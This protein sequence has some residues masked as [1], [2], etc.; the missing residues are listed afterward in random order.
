MKEVIMK[1]K[2]LVLSGALV[3]T[4]LISGIILSSVRVLADEI[5]TARSSAKASVTVSAACTLAGTVDTAHNAT[6]NAGTY[7]DEI[8]KTTLK[9]SCNDP[10]GFAIYAIGFTDDTYGK[11][12]LTNTTLGDI[13]TGTAQSGSTSNWAMKLEITGQEAANQIELQ[14]NFNNYRVI[15]DEY[16]LAA[17]KTAGTT[18]EEGV[19]L[20]STYAAYISGTQTVGTYTGKVKYTLVHPNYGPKPVAP[21][22]PTDCQK[23]GI[24]YA[25]N[26]SDIIGSMRSLGAIS[27]SETAGRVS[28][29]ANSTADL[30]APNFKREGYGFAGWSTEFNITDINNTTATIYG[31][32]E[33]IS[34]NPNDGGVDISQN[35]LILYPVWVAAET[36][37][38]MQT[39]NSTSYPAYNTAP[40]GTIIALKDERDNDV[41]AVAKLADG[42]WWMIENLRLDNEA[43]INAT[44]TQ[45]NNG[46]FGGVFN[47]LDSSEDTNFSNT[48]N[49]TP[50][51]LYSGDNVTGSYN[52]NRIPRYNNNNTNIGGTNASGANLNP[53]RNGGGTTSQWYSYGNYYSWAAAIADTTAHNTNNESVTKTS[54][55]PVNWR[56]PEGGMAYAA[57]NTSGVNV[58]GDT[59]TYRDFYNLGYKIVGSTAYENTPNNGYSYYNGANYSNLFRAYP[60]NFVYSGS[61]DG[62]S[63]S[64]RGSYG[65]YWSSSANNSN[66]AYYLRFASSR[67]CPGTSSSYKNYGFSVRC[68]AGS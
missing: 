4:T 5:V 2:E 37:V 26:A 9:A 3:F 28:A 40:N 31:P 13:V 42:N 46:A 48:T 50:N 36:S 20:A 66:T 54:I 15:P 35:G 58:T 64:T 41:Y 25:A 60:N 16:T 57:G 8:G 34:T 18:T 32:N 38:T 44:N 29:S 45:S 6:V 30:I 12:V 59:S 53:S 67:V 21:L 51:N 27:A 22:K 1:R 10:E 63:A 52:G 24:C 23:N 43:T 68:V 49:A 17:I 55:C 61:W 11:T 19:S 33:T 65:Y 47:G 56:L 39:F 62:S 7:Q 14:N